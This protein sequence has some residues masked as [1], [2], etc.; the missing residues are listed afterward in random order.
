MDAALAV[1]G[2]KVSSQ[3]NVV[4]PEG[5]ILLFAGIVAQSQRPL[6]VMI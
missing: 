1:I 6:R 5:V 3:S 2:H 4:P